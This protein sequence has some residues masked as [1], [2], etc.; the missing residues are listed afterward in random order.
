MFQISSKSPCKRRIK[1]LR[2]GGGPHFQISILFLI[3]Q[4]MTVLYL[5]FNQHRPA[6][7]KFHFYEGGKGAPIFKF[8]SYLLLVNI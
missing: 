8:N 6:K 1:L 2:S 4:H 7:E 5:K 3:D